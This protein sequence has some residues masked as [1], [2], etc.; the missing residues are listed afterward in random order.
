MRSANPPISRPK[1]RRKRSGTHPAARNWHVE[2][3]HAGPH[4]KAKTV[5]VAEEVIAADDEQREE[6]RELTQQFSESISAVTSL[7]KA[8]QPST[9]RVFEQQRKTMA[10]L[11]QTFSTPRLTALPGPTAHERMVS[12]G[13]SQQVQGELFP[14][15]Q[16]MKK[17]KPGTPP[18]VGNAAGFKSRGAR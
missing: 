14:T 17:L 4:V 3:R 2:S 18:S 11:A 12:L 15:L 9:F 7:S 6:M 5:E 10:A 8:F 16:P 13:L 1:L